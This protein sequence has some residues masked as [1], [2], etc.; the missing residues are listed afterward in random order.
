MT[1][2][3]MNWR[4]GRPPRDFVGFALE[5]KEPD[6]D[7]FWEIKNRISFPNADGSV[8]SNRVSTR[9]APIQKFRWVH[10]P[11]NADT[12][13]EFVYRVTPV[14]MNASNELSYGEAQQAPSY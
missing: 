1:L 8:N 6:M 11:V 2:L 10:F 4:S 3:A 5:Y 13:G 14:F 9:L 7:R 12:A